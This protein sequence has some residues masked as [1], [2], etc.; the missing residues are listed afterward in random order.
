MIRSGILRYSETSDNTPLNQ[1]KDIPMKRNSG[2]N[3]LVILAALVFVLGLSA[4]SFGQEETAATVTGQVTDSTGAIVAGATVVITN[5]T[6]KQE[7]RVQTND[8][9]R[10]V[11]TPLSPGTY[12]LT[13]E[14]TNFKK[15]LESGIV[16]NARDRRQLNVALEAGS[17]SELVTVMSEQNVVQDSPTGQTLISGTQVLE[18]PLQ[19]RD[20]TKLLELAPGVSSS[21]DDETGFG[22]ANRFDVSING[23]RRNAINVFVDGVSNTDVGS[24]ITLLSTPT[25]DSIKEFKVLTSNYTA[26]VGRSGG[27]TVT[28]VTKGGGNDFHGSIYD[29][30][31]NDRFNANTFFNN[32]AGRNADGTPRRRTPAGRSVWAGIG[33]YRIPVESTVEKIN[34]ARAVGADGI[35]LFSYDFTTRPGDLNPGGNYLERVR[36]AAFE[37]DVVAA[38]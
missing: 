38:P 25:V 22:L 16:L 19:N 6:T 9:G 26:E 37:P 7:R 1:E 32:R 34:V 30:A 4:V 8:D 36:R 28:L 11:I 21:L 3:L 31:R 23:M 35:V 13:A 17:V 27:G 2:R 5:D 10:Y 20:F 12:T 18:I 14:Q 29:F 33:A 24:N 15:H